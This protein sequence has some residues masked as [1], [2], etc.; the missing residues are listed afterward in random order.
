MPKGFTRITDESSY[1]KSLEGLD[2][3]QT[4][5]AVSDAENIVLRAPAG[6]GKTTTIMA[7]IAAYRYEHLNDRICAITYTRAARAEMEAR[8]QELGVHDVE[9][10][11]IHVWSRNL[12]KDLSIKYDFQIK[13]LEETQIKSIL[14]EIVE[15][16]VKRSR[17][18]KVNINILYTYI[19]GS[20]NMDITDNYR[21]TLN[22]LELRYIN[23]KRDN[24][25]YD[26]TDYPLY[27]FNVLETFDE[28]INN[29]DAL[30]VDEFQDVD[31]TQL[32]IF[33]KVNSS[34][35]FY[36]GDAWQSIFQFRGADGMVFTKLEDFTEYKLKYNY[37]SYQEIIDYAATVYLKLK[38]LAEDEEDC[39]ISEVM[40]SQSSGIICSR[41][42]GGQVA[43]INP[44][45]RIYRSDN[46]QMGKT[47]S[48]IFN[49]FMALKPMIL[50]RT[51]KQVKAIEE[52]K[53]FEVSTVHQAKGLEYPSVIV[54]D[55]TINNSED[56]NIAYVAMTRAENN[57]LVINWQQ[58]E[59][60]FKMYMNKNAFGGFQL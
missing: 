6:S 14:E 20:K 35:K 56:L 4:E 29:I 49:Q 13:I 48:E 2:K 50:C 7:A 17:V 12:L 32:E 34:K 57:L 21:R 26:F 43:V 40:Y 51:N 39:Y 19:T 59:H 30:F 58:F 44:F 24:G 15:E 16:Y 45:G 27:L 41:G 5:V 53:Y 23:Y 9:V 52:E 1:S 47:V 22:A 54:I 42:S 18:K 55:T 36:V 38:Y 11:T 31:E 46:W 8:L 3:F 60:L 33:K 28:H 37:R 25:L 10:T